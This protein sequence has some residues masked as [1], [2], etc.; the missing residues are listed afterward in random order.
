MGMIKKLKQRFYKGLYYKCRDAAFIDL[1]HRYERA[2]WEVK[3][4]SRELDKFKTSGELENS[5]NDLD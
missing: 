5:E 3:A 2:R 4:L 1:V